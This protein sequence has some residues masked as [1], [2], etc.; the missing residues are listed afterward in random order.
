[1]SRKKKEDVLQETAEEEA[2]RIAR[3]RATLQQASQKRAQEIAEAFQVFLKEQNA[4]VHVVIGTFEA[5]STPPVQMS[6]SPLEYSQQLPPAP[7]GE[8]DKDEL[9]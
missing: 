7:L 8:A 3:A 9:E 6:F 5:G 4:S 2:A 1:M